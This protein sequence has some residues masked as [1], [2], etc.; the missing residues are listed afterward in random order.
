[1]VGTAQSDRDQEK[2]FRQRGEEDKT[3]DGAPDPNTHFGAKQLRRLRRREE[4]T[5]PQDPLFKRWSQT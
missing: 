1:M 3:K 4:V 5:G 2:L